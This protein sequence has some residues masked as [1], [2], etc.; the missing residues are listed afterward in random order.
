MYID[1]F[2]HATFVLMS[3]LLTWRVL[4][5]SRNVDSQGLFGNP[6]CPKEPMGTLSAG[7]SPAGRMVLVLCAAGKLNPA[8]LMLLIL[9]GLVFAWNSIT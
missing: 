1:E 6:L 9:S 8:G 7:S 2:I 5:W 3:F 4:C